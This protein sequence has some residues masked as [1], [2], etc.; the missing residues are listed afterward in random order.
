MP[1]PQPATTTSPCSLNSRDTVSTAPASRRIPPQPA[2]RLPE[3]HPSPAPGAPRSS[4]CRPPGSASPRPPPPLRVHPYHPVAAQHFPHAREWA[5]AHRCLAAGECDARAHRGR[6]QAIQR[7][8]HT[9][10]LQRLVVLHHRRNRL[11]IRHGARRGTLVSLG[12]ISIMNRMAVTPLRDQLNEH[13]RTVRREWERV[14]ACISRCCLSV[15]FQD[16]GLACAASS[17]HSISA[18]KGGFSPD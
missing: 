12:I 14:K 2:A 9:R 7:D 5:M 18:E 4:R 8:Q 13:T 15:D 10:L 6:M 16:E 17:G 3:S 1:Q 11:R